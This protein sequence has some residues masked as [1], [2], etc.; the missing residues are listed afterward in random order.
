ME[1]YNGNFILNTQSSFEAMHQPPSHETNKLIYHI[2]AE[3]DY[4]RSWIL[5]SPINDEDGTYTVQ[6][7]DSG[8]I[9]EV[10][11]DEISN[12]NLNVMKIEK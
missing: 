10:T 7:C 3:K 2:T 1:Q 4:V 11:A 12:S 8:Y 9:Y 6:D 5:N